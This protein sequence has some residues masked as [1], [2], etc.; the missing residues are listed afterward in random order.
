MYTTQREVR[1]AFW[2]EVHDGAYAGL[3][4]TRNLITDYTGKGK[5]HNTDT[6]CAFVDYVDGLS[7]SGEISEDLANKVT[8]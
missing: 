7:K 6:R 2:Q 8:L 4:V 1:N 3:D 5:M